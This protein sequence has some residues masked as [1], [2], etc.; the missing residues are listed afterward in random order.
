M[1][2]WGEGGKK[3]GHEVLEGYFLEGEM[4]LELVG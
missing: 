1:E 2:E 4:T 3:R